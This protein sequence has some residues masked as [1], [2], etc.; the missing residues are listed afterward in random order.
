M[1]KSTLFLLDTEDQ[2]TSMKLTENNNP[3]VHLTEV[4]QHFQLMGQWHNNLLKMGS[5]ISNLHY[6]M[7]IMSL[8][9]ELYQPTL[10]T[11]TAAECASTLLGTLSSRAM[12]PDDLITFVMEEAQHCIINDK[13]TKNTE[14]T[15]AALGKKQRTR[16]QC[17]NKGKEKSTPG[18]T[19]ENCKNTGHTKADYWSKGGGKEG[20]GPRGWN[21]KKGEKKPETVEAVE[22]TGNADEIST[23]ICTSDYVE[24]A[25]TLNVPK[26]RLGACIDSG[27]SWHYSLDHDVFINYCPIN[28]TT[29]TTAN[30]CKLK[31][32]GKGNVQIE[33]P[34]GAKC[35]KTILKEAIHAPDMA[36]ALILVGR[37]DDTKCST[38]FSG[39]MCTICNPS[40]RTMATIPCANSLYHV[41]APEDPPTVNYVSIAMSS[42][43]SV[44]PTRNLATSHLQLSSTWLQK[45]TLLVSSLTLSQS[46][47]SARHVP[48]PKQ[49][50]NPSQ[51]N[52]KLT[53]WNMESTSTGTCG[54]QLQSK[55]SAEI[56]MWQCA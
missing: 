12:K 18:A 10:Q 36:F 34:N 39:G 50:S 4:K 49:L 29:I 25:N 51:R 16:K 31:A 13:R 3:K 22:A 45:A 20:Q 40:S 55:A 33:L 54:D 46:L 56:H 37:L 26:S 21:S 15:L 7:I 30:S 42:W 6:N 43:P 44:K 23:F 53:Q 35:T 47:N 1:T 28:N 11:I 17:S 9:P 24:V 38:T 52:W 41:T 27:A 2:L 8:L 5:T 19:C 48:R 14:S 32:L